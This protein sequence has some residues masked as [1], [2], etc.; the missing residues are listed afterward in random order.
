M[1]SVKTYAFVLLTAAASV[2]L[3]GCSDDDTDSIESNVEQQAD[4]AKD[5]LDDL[6]DEV[7][8]ELD[9]AGESIDEGTARAQA[10]AFRQRLTELGQD[11]ARLRAG[12]GARRARRVRATVRR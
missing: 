3:V 5:Q 8:Q 7:E 11:R 4:E 2:A 10:E 1:R 6:Q 9:E 12:G